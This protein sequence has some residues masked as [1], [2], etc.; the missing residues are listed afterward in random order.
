[1]INLGYKQAQGG[2]TL[3]IE[4]LDVEG[5]ITFLVYVDDIIVVE[6][7]EK[8]KLILKQCLTR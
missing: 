3:F 8:E 4:H 6:N 2:Y 5:V 7:D 1:M